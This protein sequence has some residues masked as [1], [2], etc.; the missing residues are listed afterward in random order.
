MK[1]EWHGARKSVHPSLPGAPK[2]PQGGGGFKW[3]SE[4][5]K[6]SQ[7]KGMEGQLREKEQWV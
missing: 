4:G 1:T 2:A 6:V 7:A 3:S 5:W